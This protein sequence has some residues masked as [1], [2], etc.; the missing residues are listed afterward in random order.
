MKFAIASY[1]FHRFLETGTRDVFDYIAISSELG[2]TQLDPWA[3]HLTDRHDPTTIAR[4][5]RQPGVLSLLPG[6]EQ[7]LTD[8]RAAA[9][10]AGLPFGC[11]AVDGGHIYEPTLEARNANREIAYHW[12]EAAHFLDAK[13]MRI[14]AG[15]PAA[16]TD[17]IFQI[18]IEGYRDLVA[19]AAALGIEI[20][21]ENHWGPSQYPQNVIRILSAVEGLGLL[22]DSHNWAEGYKR[23]G[24]EQTAQFA[25]SIHIK[26]FSFDENGF[27]PSVDIPAF[28]RIVQDTGYEGVWGIESVPD[29]GDE[30]GA[31]R[32]TITLLRRLID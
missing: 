8:V 28:V 20:L 14:D 11:I 3:A 25:R 22:L 1:S 32:K 19:R 13:Q 2:A 12:L 21:M 4:V 5:G 6:S 7:F 18:I 31:V 16:P 17:D 23:Q 29:D 24:W 26:T 10:R 27:E 15:G 9:E 30:M